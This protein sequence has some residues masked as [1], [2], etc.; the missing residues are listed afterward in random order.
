LLVEA[1]Y[2]SY[3]SERRGFEFLWGGYFQF[4]W[5]FQ[6][7]YGFGVDSASYI[8]QYQEP[9]WGVKG[10]WGVRLTTLPPSVSRL[11]RRLTTMRAFTACYRNVF[12]YLYR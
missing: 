9:S 7:H 3:K 6:P 8:N 1:L 10:G 12:F 11:S 2:Y 4:T 5:S